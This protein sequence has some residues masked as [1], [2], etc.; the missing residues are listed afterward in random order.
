MSKPKI[1]VQ[2]DSDPQPS[3]FDGVVAVDAGVAQLFRQGG[4]EPSHVR[5]L[6]FGAMF[7]RGVDD[8]RSTAIF[9]GGSNVSAGEALLAEVR[10]TFFGPMR[11]SVMLDSNGA[12]TTAA[13]AVLSA[14]KH[15][16]LKDAVALVLAATG[17]VGS[18]AA[19]LLALAGA[20]VRVASR[21]LARAEAVCRQLAER[22]P[23]AQ[24][25]AVETSSC[26]QTAA[27]LGEVQIVI[28]AGAPGVEIV[29]EAARAAARSLQVAIDLSAVPPLGLAGVEVTDK[30]VE[31]A[32]VACY[33]AIGV[34]GTKMKIHKAAV[35]QLFEANDQVL[36]AVEIYRIGQQ[37]A[38]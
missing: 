16:P 30:A 2:L 38:G 23:G 5:E 37:L 3:V 21:Q 33:G 26:E 8:L 7:T 13:A 32:G 17:P 4:V 11:V 15:C 18:R 10:R 35:R 9:I 29:S 31:R 25:T 28:A 12:N 19:W 22:V 6:A 20:R 36:D 34:G 24:V 14:A 27:A 1:L